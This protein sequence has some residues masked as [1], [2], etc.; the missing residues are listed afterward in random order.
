MRHYTFQVVAKSDQLSH[1]R[2]LGPGGNISVNNHSPPLT[3]K[4][5]SRK[6][7]VITRETR[8]F[9]PAL[10]AALE[11]IVGEEG[12]IIDRRLLLNSP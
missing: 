1:L 4:S 10:N 7:K 9:L 2:F 5:S 3:F 6:S 8:R 11:A 12:W